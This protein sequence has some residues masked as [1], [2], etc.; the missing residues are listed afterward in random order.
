MSEN[1]QVRPKIW[2]NKIWLDYLKNDL[3]GK[4]ESVSEYNGNQNAIVLKANCCGLE[5]KTRPRTIKENPKCPTCDRR[6]VTNWNI[7]SVTEFVEKDEEYEMLSDTYSNR[8]VKLK[9]KHLSCGKISEMAF[10]KFVNGQRCPCGN[11]IRKYT[12]DEVKKH[13]EDSGKFKLLSK[14]YE[15]SKKKM[16]LKCLLH[17]NEFKIS[18]HHMIINGHG[19]PECKINSLRRDFSSVEKEVTD[20]SYNMYKIDG[21]LYID[22]KQ[23]STFTHN[24][25][26]K[27]FKMSFNTFRNDGGRCPH[28]IE[29]HKL[30][31]PEMR[32]VDVLILDKLLSFETEFCDRR[33]RL[34]LP[35]RFDF[36]LSNIIKDKLV[37]IEYD[38]EAHFKPIQF[39][40]MS[41]TDSIDDFEL[42]KLR[43]KTKDSFVK[44]YANEYLL[45]RVNYENI[46]SFLLELRNLLKQHEKVGYLTEDIVSTYME[47][48]RIK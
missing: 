35:L 7:V 1:K 3:N 9:F 43:D 2:T 10:D 34:N 6:K 39:K 21:E 16:S 19:C 17:D 20:L 42:R 18:R 40:E 44:E 41:I 37:L 14:T 26:G 22:T 15:S 31:N 38:G 33:C 27:S 46:N 8:K 47:T 23:E 11:T 12:Y 25:C 29:E 32:I 24:Y 28:C 5:F 48:Y 4:F 13:I 30:S 45:F 36:A